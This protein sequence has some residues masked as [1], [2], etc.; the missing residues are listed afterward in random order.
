MLKLSIALAMTLTL[1]S[2][3]GNKIVAS[4]YCAIAE[5]ISFSDLDTAETRRQIDRHNVA[6]D[7]LCAE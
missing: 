4:N 2:G 6:W 7:T 1:L 5:P 3:C